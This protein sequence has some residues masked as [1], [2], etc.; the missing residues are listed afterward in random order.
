MKHTGKTRITS[1]LLAL[2]MLVSVLLQ[3]TVPVFAQEEGAESETMTGETAVSQVL[4][5]S[6]SEEQKPLAGKTIACVGDSITAAYGVTKDETDYVTLLA[7]RLGMNY[8]RLG[9]SGTTLCTDGSRVCNIRRLTEDQL[10]GADVV[11]IAMGINDFCNA[12]G[13]YYKLGDIHSTDTSTI[14]GAARMWCQRIA[15]LRKTDSLSNTQF[16]FVTPVI[17]SWNNSVTSARDWDQSKKNVHGYTLRNLC[18][19]IIEV[20]KLYEVPVID[21]NLLSGMYYVDAEDQNTA[22]FGGDGVHPGVKGHEMMANALANVLLQKNLRDDHEH[23]FGSWI[24]T[25]W[26]T[27][28]PGE[29]QRICS[30]CSAAESRMAE[31]NDTHSYIPAVTPPTCTE[32]GYTTYTCT[33]C[34]DSYAGDEVD[35]LGHS[36]ES[37]RCAICGAPEPFESMTMRFDD[38]LDMTGKTV[39]I[40]DAGTGVVTLEE[41]ALV[42]TGVGEAQIRIDG[43]LHHIV[44][45]KAKINIVTIMGQSN[46]GNHFANATSDVTCPI[47]T[48]YY[49]KYDSTEPEDYTQ[50]SMGFHTPLLAELYAQSAAAG[51][52]V[53]NVL[54]WQEGITSKNGQSIVQWAASKTDTRG[55]DGTVTMLQNCVAYYEQHSDS[56]E[57]VGNGVYWLQ[58]ESDVAMAPE[59]YIERFMAMWNRLKTAGAEYVAFF[60]VRKGT[61]LNGDAHEDLSYTGSLNAQLQMVNHNADLFMASTITENWTGTASVEHRIDI[62]DYLTLM[63]AYGSAPSHNDAYGNA[64]TFEDGILTTTMK[65]LYGSNNR[66]HYGKFGYGIIGADAAVHMYTALHTTDFAIVKSLASGGTEEQ[67]VS[68]AGDRVTLDITELE[69]N[70]AFRAAC[71]STA[72][73]LKVTVTEGTAD[74][75]NA[76]TAKGI[77]T[78][79][80]IDPQL[81]RA[82]DQPVITVTYTP[83]KGIAGSVNY[84]IVNNAPDQPHLY[85]WDFETDLNARDENGTIVNGFGSTPLQG[86]YTLENG[87]LKATDLHLALEQAIPLSGAKEWSIEWKFGEVTN[88]SKGFLFSSH[89]RNVIGNKAFYHV[90]TGQFM[91]SEYADSKGYRNYTLDSVRVQTGDVMKVT[92]RF[93]GETGR[94]VL[95]LWQNGKPVIEDFQRKGSFNGAASDLDMTGYPLDGTFLLGYMGA[96]SFLPVTDEFEYIRVIS[97]AAALCPQ[98]SYEAAVTP[99]TCT[100]QGYTT[101]TC[102]VCGKSYVGDEVD[103]LGHDF[104]DYRPNGDGTLTGHCSRCGES[105]TLPDPAIRCR[106][107]SIAVAD[108]TGAPQSGIPAGVCQVTVSVTKVAM[109]GDFVLWL[110]A[111]T[112]QEQFVCMVPLAVENLDAGETRSLTAQL[113]NT[114]GLVGNLKIFCVES[115]EHPAPQ[116]LEKA[117]LPQ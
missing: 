106:I 49:W 88:A 95:S 35:A 19:A 46:A 47:G 82:Y 9:D 91:I 42:A 20:A 84:H 14:Y 25:T 74:I 76:V 89:N 43:E 81:L 75:T 10:Q 53:K 99:P 101:Y 65:T 34:G 38:H 30:I 31:P 77:E 97:D 96:G 56:Y 11:T 23:T 115:C 8:I 113:D 60:R 78:S 105:D 18:N 104:T 72:G 44:V 93:D 98:H 40:L 92:N 117:F 87:R 109:E 2:L 116:G 17:T 33:V 28:T 27:C 12:A 51:D 26:P 45:E 15:E 111:Y 68:R 103:A 108:E 83:V 58:G 64:A 50:P 5:Q 39:E 6:E 3:V 36:Y 69:E 66:C 52:P 37:G 112:A 63:E 32:R 90:S 29:Q 85:Q 80:T 100:E 70:L 107:N 73:T 7:Q 114:A 62:R 24:T 48:A 79:G 110:A 16:Y 71:G 22:V 102:T 61:S 94:S 21:L 13:D 57:I 59:A 54:V 55:T 86:S 67:L 1:L 4:L 41:N